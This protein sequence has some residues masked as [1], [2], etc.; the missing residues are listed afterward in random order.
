MND[1]MN[2]AIQSMSTS[3]RKRSKVPCTRPLKSGLVKLVLA[4]IPELIADDLQRR[5][6]SM[7]IKRSHYCAMVLEQHLAKEQARGN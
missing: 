5:A 4:G 1:P 7:G 2:E 3:V 6:D